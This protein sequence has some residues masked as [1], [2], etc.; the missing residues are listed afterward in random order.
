[1]S[2]FCAINCRFNAY[3]IDRSVTSALNVHLCIYC[4]MYLRTY[5]A[6]LGEEQK[7]K[8]KLRLGLNLKNYKAY[9]KLRYIL[10]VIFYNESRADNICN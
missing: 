6:G 3:Q 2:L 9:A 10:N 1:M 5:T 7:A 8:I 4:N